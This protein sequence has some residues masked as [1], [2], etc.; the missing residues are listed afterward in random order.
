MPAEV[1]V[2]Y[3]ADPRPNVLIA[4]AAYLRDDVGVEQENSKR[5]VAATIFRSV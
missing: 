1:D 4:A 3:F 2:L 5:D